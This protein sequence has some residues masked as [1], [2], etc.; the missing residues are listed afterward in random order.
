MFI[1]IVVVSIGCARIAVPALGRAC[2][3][4]KACNRWRHSTRAHCVRHSAGA[5]GPVCE[6]SGP[7][8]LP[9]NNAA[10]DSRP[11]PPSF[12]F[13]SPRHR[14]KLRPRMQ[15]NRL[16]PEVKANQTEHKALEILDKVVENS[17]AIGVFGLLH[18]CQRT[19][20]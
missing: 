18:V 16:Y 3:V 13:S 11:S 10:W 20:L 15:L 6:H 17:Q 8:P 7:P 19:D 14:A 9:R 1:T 12:G 4:F 5:L 2:N